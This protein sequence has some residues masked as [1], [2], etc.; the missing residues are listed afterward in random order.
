LIG[1]KNPS[2]SLYDF[3]IVSIDGFKKALHAKFEGK[4]DSE[5]RSYI[6]SIEVKITI[7]YPKDTDDLGSL[8]D[9]IIDLDIDSNTAVIVIQYALK[10]GK[11]NALFDGIAD[12]SETSIKTLLKL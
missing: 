2:F 12:E 9:F 5:I 11:I 6:P 1:D 7:E 4:E 3:S 8:G 10:D